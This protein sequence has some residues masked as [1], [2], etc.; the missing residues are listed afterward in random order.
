[1][2]KIQPHIAAHVLRIVCWM[3]NIGWGLRAWFSA[4]SGAAGWQVSGRACLHKITLNSGPVSHTTLSPP[5]LLLSILHPLPPG[6]KKSPLPTQRDKINQSV[7]M[8]SE[9]VRLHNFLCKYKG[10]WCDLHIIVTLLRDDL[11]D[12]AL[13]GTITMQQPPQWQ[14]QP[15]D[16]PESNQGSE[17]QTLCF[18][19]NNQKK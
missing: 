16:C 17:M 19:H 18:P 7:T 15:A 6:L 10:I 13:S 12:G 1:M 3:E 8:A 11:I 5:L 4:E 9:F 2:D 14:I